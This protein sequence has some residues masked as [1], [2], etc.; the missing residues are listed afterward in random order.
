MYLNLN[1][2]AYLSVNQSTAK[3]SNTFKMSNYKQPLQNADQHLDRDTYNINF[4]RK[5]PHKQVVC[6]RSPDTGKS[7]HWCRTPRKALVVSPSAAPGS[8]LSHH[9]LLHCL[10]CK[11]ILQQIQIQTINMTL[12]L[13]GQGISSNNAS[14]SGWSGKR[15]QTSTD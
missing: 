1:A 13:E 3:F 15:C 2:S 12:F 5:S 11:N 7:A 9:C 4:G 14:R 8:A 10:K 6:S